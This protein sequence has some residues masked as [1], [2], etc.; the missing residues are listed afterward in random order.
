MEMADGQ[1]QPNIF[2]RVAGDHFEDYRE[3]AGWYH[4]TDWRV[5][6]EANH[7]RRYMS[8]AEG[9]RDNQYEYYLKKP[10]KKL[11]AKPNVGARQRKKMQT[12]T[13]GVL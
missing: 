12:A 3:H 8:V 4:V 13:I 7:Q 9:L 6:D 10:T 2:D 11:S 5:E 1:G